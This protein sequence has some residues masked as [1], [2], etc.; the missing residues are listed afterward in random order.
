MLGL[1]FVPYGET[2]HVVIERVAAH[3]VAEAVLGRQR[4]ASVL[5][6]CAEHQVRLSTQCRKA[7]AL[8]LTSAH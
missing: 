4:G 3:R 2:A 1:V 7:V 6:P 5:V 8:H